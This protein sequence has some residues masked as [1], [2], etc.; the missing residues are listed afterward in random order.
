MVTT[1]RDSRIDP[2]RIERDLRGT[3]PVGAPFDPAELDGLPAPVQRYLT[4]SIAAGTP[5]SSVA[6]LHMRGEIRLGRWI[7]FTAT[8]VLAPHRGF[9]WRARAARVI[10]G[11]DAY[12]A[13]VGAMR[14]RLLGVPLVRASG[15]DVSRSA[16]GR[17]AA[18]AVW[19]PTTL[20]PRFGVAWSAPSDDHVV[21]SYRLDAT[22]VQL[23]LWLDEAAHPTTIAFERW[24]D[25]TRT[26]T[27]GWHRFVGRVREHRSFGG[28]T[29]PSAGTWG[30]DLDAGRGEFFR[31]RLTDV[32]AG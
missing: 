1:Q 21:A 12:L 14:W 3:A 17:C 15:A 16:A 26:G 13:G 10:T 20:L 27:H 23:H 9:L 24:G 28:L 22:P 32:V 25:P 7:P 31:C 30:W 29:V 2:D 19:V 11:F 18:E 4:A 5:A 6:T 8:E